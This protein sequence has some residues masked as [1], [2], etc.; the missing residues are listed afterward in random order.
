[1]LS[2]VL[3]LGVWD[4]HP[5]PKRHTAALV[6]RAGLGIS[7]PVSSTL[8]EQ[9]S[10]LAPECQEEKLSLP[11]NVVW[12]WEQPSCLHE[13]TSLKDGTAQQRQ[14]KK[15]RKNVSYWHNLSFTI[16]ATWLI[17]SLWHTWCL[18]Y[19]K[20]LKIYKHWKQMQ[21]PFLD[22]KCQNWSLSS[23]GENKLHKSKFE[24]ILGAES[25]SERIKSVSGVYVSML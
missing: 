7:A 14:A 16:S 24:R 17:N 1:M 13:E 25:I 10:G 20:P 3:S 5:F 19:P 9:L 6:P 18:N 21:K 8:H 15:N 23:R 4:S 2:S 11:L 22:A 12:G